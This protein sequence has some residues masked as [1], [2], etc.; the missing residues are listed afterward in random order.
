[1]AEPMEVEPKVVGYED[2][3]ESMSRIAAGIRETGT[4]SR[5]TS[6]EIKNLN[7]PIWSMR[8]SLTGIRTSIRMYN[9]HLFEA[10]RIMRDVGFIGRTM[11]RM[12]QAY[13]IAQM[14][15]AD[16]TRD[17]KTAQEKVSTVQ[18]QL[19]QMQNEG[20]KS[21]KDYYDL[22]MQLITA[23]QDEKKA[24]ADLSRA[25]Q[26]NIV[27]YVGMALQ[28]NDILSRIISLDY[29]TTV[30]GATLK[31]LKKYQDAFNISSAIGTAL[32]WE[33]VKS[34]VAS[35]LATTHETAADAAHT[36][37]LWLK[38]KALAVVH[39]LTPHGWAILAVAGAIAA[40]TLAWIAYEESMAK[41]TKT[42]DELEKKHVG[43][44]LFSALQQTRTMIDRTSESWRRYGHITER[45]ITIHFAPTIYG[46]AA[47]RREAYDEFIDSIRRKGLM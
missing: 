3:I 47:S 32:K 14:R 35:A 23:Q 20:V 8:R 13:N 2:F 28:V 11:T 10:G 37:A 26:E 46:E 30:F 6:L 27:G 4:V 43:S 36:A 5:D 40:G 29:H 33:S 45:A 25:Q 34:S 19:N 12:W 16:A 38:A 31:F 44:G 7:K 42:A 41:T 9:A 1:M 24:R 39:A 21:G 17:L 22:Q 18:R 15:V